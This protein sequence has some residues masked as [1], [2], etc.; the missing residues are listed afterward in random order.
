V[1]ARDNAGAT[2]PLSATVTV[3]SGG[4]GGGGG[5]TINCATNALG[6]GVTGATEVIDLSWTNPQNTFSRSMGPNDAVVVRFTTSSVISD[7][8]GNV[9][10]SNPNFADYRAYLSATACDFRQPPVL[11]WGALGSGISPTTFFSVGVQDS[12]G[13]LILQPN[14]TYYYN[15]KLAPSGSCNSNNCNGSWNLRPPAGS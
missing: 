4:G 13:D 3:S 12:R 5:G 1:T 8:Y 7:H 15:I 10:G 11:D 2:F 9:Y 14:T 6:T